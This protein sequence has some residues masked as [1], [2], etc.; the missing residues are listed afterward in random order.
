MSMPFSV[1]ISGSPFGYYYVLSS[2]FFLQF[3]HLFLANRDKV[4]VV[5]FPALLRRC[6]HFPLP[7]HHHGY[8]H[9]PDQQKTCPSVEHYGIGL[10]LE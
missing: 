9:L 2:R 5:Y 4:F 1:L 6:L 7:R 10:Y 3:V 8:V